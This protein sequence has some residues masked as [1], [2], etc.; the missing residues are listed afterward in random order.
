MDFKKFAETL[1]LEEDEFTEL[2]ELFLD[3]CAGDLEKLDAAVTEVNAEEAAK[4]AHSMKGAAGNLGFVELSDLA[5]AIEH[6][7]RQGSLDGTPENIV[8][9]KEKLGE[10]E[11]IV[12]GG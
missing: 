8:V 5:K 9:F 11:R 1:G 2:A 10:L 7:A 3:T 12:R 4:A 6:N